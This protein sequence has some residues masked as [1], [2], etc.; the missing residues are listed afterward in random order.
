MPM[1]TDL[2]IVARDAETERAPI[3]E[4]RTLVPQF[5]ISNDGDYAFAA[6][7]IRRL[8]EEAQ[9]IKDKSDGFTRAAREFI[10]SVEGFYTPIR[11]AYADAERVLRARMGAYVQAREAARVE[12]MKANEPAPV[13]VTLQGV[14]TRTK[15]KFRIVSE[16]L[17]PRDFCSP[18]EKKIR[19]FIA[20]NGGV[21]ILYPDGIPGVE[22]YQEAQITIRGDK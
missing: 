11:D 19:S 1:K 12:A 3:V 9:R 20:T 2:A 16:A 14:S 18:D 10:A 6:N 4:I 13:P 5:E 22:L 21:S 17:V 8:K 7:M 15:T